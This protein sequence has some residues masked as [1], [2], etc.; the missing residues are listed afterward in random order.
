MRKIYPKDLLTQNTG[1]VL[2][3]LFAI[4][5]AITPCEFIVTLTFIALPSCFTSFLV[6]SKLIG[7]WQE[8]KATAGA[9]WYNLPRTVLT[10]ELK[11][12]L[13]LLRM[14][15]TLDPKRF[16]KKE[17]AKKNQVPEY[18]QVG[19]VIEG[20]TEFFSA[21][22]SNKERK[23]TLV[24]EVLA[25][26][27]T[28]Q[29][30]KSKYRDIQR[31]KTSGRKDYYKAVKAQRKGSNANGWSIIARFC[32]YLP[33]SDCIVV[34]F[35][36]IFGGLGRLGICAFQW[37]EMQGFV[38]SFGRSKVTSSSGK[39]RI[40]VMRTLDP[41]SMAFAFGLFYCRRLVE[42]ILSIQHLSRRIK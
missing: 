36:T 35:S 40:S 8:K 22:L 27:K 13:Q 14:R 32:F 23:R 41:S 21:R 38:A 37:L 19:T 16:Y 42:S 20:P 7:C 5:R 29:R 39:T 24:E 3:T 25:G 2:G 26:E 34:T 17:N 28:T 18:S 15:S 4:M 11:R 10:P 12:D 6:W 1:P 30:F 31:A 9:D 33:K